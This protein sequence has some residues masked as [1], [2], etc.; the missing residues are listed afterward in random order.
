[1]SASTTAIFASVAVFNAPDSARAA[2]MSTSRCSSITVDT[3]SRNNS[4]ASGC[5]IV[6]PISAATT[7]RS[8]N[9]AALRTND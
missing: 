5:E 7:I 8:P 9:C 6:S 4:N 2:A 3:V 1:M